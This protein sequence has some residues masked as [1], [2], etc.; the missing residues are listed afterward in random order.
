MVAEET[1]AR[2]YVSFSINPHEWEPGRVQVTLAVHG[3][4]WVAVRLRGL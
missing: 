2:G 3:K 4:E 1:I